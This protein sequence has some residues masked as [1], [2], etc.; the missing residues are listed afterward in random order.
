MPYHHGWW[1]DQLNCGGH[2]KMLIRPYTTDGETIKQDEQAEK[3]DKPVENVTK[4]DTVNLV[5]NS[6][7]EAV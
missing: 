4:Q 1:Y 7:N 3:A 2:I 6:C 5:C